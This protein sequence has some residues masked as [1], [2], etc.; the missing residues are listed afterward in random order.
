[1]MLSKHYFANILSVSK[2]EVILIIVEQPYFF[3]FRTSQTKKASNA[4]LYGRM[5][6]N[7][8]HK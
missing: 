5:L 7:V 8:T 3:Y 6:F 1:M 4:D 2:T